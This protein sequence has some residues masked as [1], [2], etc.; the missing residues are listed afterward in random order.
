MNAPGPASRIIIRETNAD[1]VEEILWHRRQMFYD[2]G[3][4]DE[5]MLQAI[6]DS[7]RPYIK[8]YLA[9]LSYRGWFAIAPDGHVAAGAGVLISPLVSGPFSPHDVHRAYLLNVYTYPKFRKRGLARA[10]TQKAIDW[11]R[12]EGFKVLWLHT[13]KSGRPLYES[14]GFEATNEMRLILQ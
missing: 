10:L 13:S 11:C 8:R 5:A 7:S 12:A 2:M 9:E 1:D 6:L 3:H 4:Q 14:L